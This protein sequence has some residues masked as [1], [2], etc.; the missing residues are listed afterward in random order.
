M[1]EISLCVL[2]NL[3]LIFCCCLL[4]LQNGLLCGHDLEIG[5]HFSKTNKKRKKNWITEYISAK[6][7]TEIFWFV[8]LFASLFFLWLARFFSHYIIWFQ[9]EIVCAW[10][11]YWNQYWTTGTV[12]MLLHT[13]SLL[14]VLSSMSKCF[15]FL[16]IF[17]YSFESAF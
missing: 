2:V 15:A 3:K 13:H 16:S 4:H 1:Y 5:N 10:R 6:K 17:I 11:K 14:D 8:N 7:K 9:I 12:G